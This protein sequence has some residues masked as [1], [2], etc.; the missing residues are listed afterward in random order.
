[1][2]NIY[3]EESVGAIVRKLENNF[4]TGTTTKSK[5]VDESLYEDINKIEAYLNSKHISG[6]T[7]SMGRE[8]P[9]FNI[10]TA[11]RNIWY[12]ATDIDRKNIKFKP[13]KSSD[14]FPAFAATEKLQTWMRKENFGAF[15]NDWGITQA[16]YNEAV[17][18][19]VEKDGRLIPSVI[20]WTRIICDSIDFENN[21]KIE[22]LEFTEG[23]LYQMEGYDKEEIEKLCDTRKARETIGRTNKDNNAD[24]IKLY[25]VHGL[26]PKSMRTG[27]DSDDDIYEQQ[28]FVL[29]FVSSGKNDGEYEDFLL[30]SGKEEKDPYMLTALMREID[31]SIS[32]KG[33]VKTLFEAQWMMNHTAKAIKDQ[34][35]LASKLIFQTSDG[36]FV[37]QNA[38]TAIESGDILIHAPNEPI[39]QINNGS[40]DITSLQNFGSQWKALAQEIASTPDALMGNNAPSGTAW[41]QVEA[42]QSEA[43][44]LFELMTENRGLDT[45][46]IMREFVIP[47]IKK[48]LNS[49]EEIVAMLEDYDIKKIDSRFIKNKATKIT[50]EQIVEKILNDET[51]TPEDQALL[52]SINEKGLEAALKENG[53]T[54]FFVPSELDDMTWADVFKDFEWNII[55]D[56]TGESQFNREDLATLS[57]VFSTIGSNPAVLTDPN[58]KLLFNKILSITGAVNPVELAQPEAPMQPQQPQQPLQMPTPMTG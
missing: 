13:S 25:E 34:L 21:P 52:Q 47:Y 39:T 3:Q 42:L 37:G 22:I 55:V 5:Y 26:F 6:D 14:I 33:S 9:F 7:D 46:R 43:N 41:R 49:K 31:G 38:L 4:I 16:G 30:Y 58:A 36:N 27:L 48:G 11:S 50:N 54:R 44:S 2:S 8:K 56:V 12:R 29:S 35:D 40:H 10:V 57:T 17:L 24:Y 53:N 18:K 1:M 20:P 28:M 15:L 51:P 45:E 19:F 32:L 23:Q